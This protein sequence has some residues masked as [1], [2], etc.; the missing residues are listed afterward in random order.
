MKRFRKLALETGVVVGW[1]L[2]VCGSLLYI[3]E[4]SG[5]LTESVNKALRTALAASGETLTVKSVELDWFEPAVALSGVTL[6]SDEGR[7][8]EIEQ[9]RFVFAPWLGRT[10]GLERIEIDTAHVQLSASLSTRVR[11]FLRTFSGSPGNSERSRLPSLVANGLYVEVKTP[12][13][14]LCPLGDLD[15]RYGSSGDD[16]PRLSGRLK[17]RSWWAGENAKHIQIYG[18]EITPGVMDLHA[19]ARSLALDLEEVPEDLPLGQIEDYHP[20]ARLD[21]QARSTLYLDG[22][23]PPRG[24]IR[25]AISEGEALAPDVSEP[26]RGVEAALEAIFAPEFE[27]NIFDFEAWSGRGEISARWRETDIKT[28]LRIG[29]FARSGALAEAWLRGPEVRAQDEYIDEMIALMRPI[30]KIGRFVA[31]NLGGRGRARLTVAMLLDDL[32]TSNDPVAEHLHQLVHVRSEGN[33][34]LSYHG[35][36]NQEGERKWGFPLEVNEISGDFIYGR[37]PLRPQPALMGI[38]ELVGNHGAGP[39]HCSG[40]ISSRLPDQTES[41]PLPLLDLSIQ[42]EDLALEER[43]RAAAYG[44]RG[45][46]PEDELWN[47]YRP[48]GGS[49]GLDLRLLMEPGRQTM[50][51][52]VDVDLQ[53]VRLH[54]APIPAPLERTRGQVRVVS[55]GRG[56]SVASVRTASELASGEALDLVARVESDRNFGVSQFAEARVRKLSLKGDDVRVLSTAQPAVRETLESFAPKGFVDARCTW[57]TLNEDLPAELVVDITPHGPCEIDPKVFTMNTRGLRGRVLIEAKRAPTSSKETSSTP[58]W[59]TNVRVVPLVGT[60]GAGIDVALS[61]E[62][63]TESESRLAIHGA[64][65]RSSNRRLLGSLAESI[66]AA[67]NSSNRLDL[68]SLRVNGRLDFSADLSFVERELE[69]Q[70]A[71]NSEFLVFLRENDLVSERGFN[72]SRL[73]GRVRLDINSGRLQAQRLDAVLGSTAVQ[74]SNPILHRVDDVLRF[75]TQLDAQGLPLDHEHLSLFLD[76]ETLEAILDELQWRGTID[77][78]DAVLVL[79]SRAD[80]TTRLTLQGPATLSD[81]YM[82]MGVPVSIRS[83]QANVDSLVF[84]GGRTRGWGQLSDLFG[85][86][87]GRSLESAEMLVSYVEPRVSLENVHGR[88]IDSEGLVYPLGSRVEG[89]SAQ[90]PGGSAF[91]IDLRAPFP[92]EAAFALEN[93][94]VAGLTQG[95]F[96]TDIANSGRLQGELRLNGN[97]EEL[98]QIR[99]TG[100]LALTRG[101]LWSVPVVRTL[102]SRLGLD[103]TAVFDSMGTR[104]E[105]SEGVIHM[106]ELEAH[107]PILK[108]VGEGTLDFDGSLHHDLEVNYSL[109]DK[110]GFL[111]KILYSIQNSLLRI[112]IRGDMERPQVILKSALSDLFGER[113]KRALPLPDISG[114]PQRF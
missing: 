83:A 69:T 35:Q 58:I 63:G 47:L 72:L 42:A 55:S 25:V 44:L 39:V 20:S 3:A 86:V 103:D 77:V 49:L 14:G 45:V 65:I 37:E 17:T 96:A 30:D 75:E 41:I 90:S 43:F 109:I 8:V 60:W 1:I 48:E 57:S 46:I 23:R 112:S 12:E 104:F 19:V 54:W 13:W 38:A 34:T 28:Q 66:A 9:V 61:G 82:Q 106:K 59:N 81:V 18:T 40:L 70:L 32:W 89:A 113:E 100:H 84:E 88:F 7:D 29:R 95:L 11:T 93:V 33:A 16:S 52:L 36:A 4:R 85:T 6:A 78:H 94:D 26:V 53:N 80:G 10:L 97:L 31:H 24:S 21:L 64:G 22:S 108:L 56:R 92:F 114:L 68:T 110:F 5:L 71:Q 67:G 102:F 15:L 51:S 73:D 98:L 79:D 111:R 74:L 87:A 107:S 101:Q 76:E 27:Q 91:A 2:I 62:F 50:A 105:I 99:G